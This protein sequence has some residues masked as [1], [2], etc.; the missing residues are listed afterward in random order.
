MGFQGKSALREKRALCGICP[1]GCWVIVTYDKAGR[2]DK[3]RPDESSDL[4]IICKLGEHSADIVYS[5]DR[6]LYPLRRKGP[7]GTYEFER[8]SWDT[9]YD[10]IADRLTGIKLHFGPEANAVYTGRG[11]FELS[12]CDVFQPKGVAVSSASSILFPFGSP[13]TMGVGSL[14]YVSFAMIAPHVT[15]GGMLINMFS[16][17]ENAQLIV[18]WGANPATDCPPLDLKRI[19]EAHGRGAEVVVI[20]PRRTMTAKL[21]NAEWI[22]VRSGT[23]GALAL[24]MCNVL[25]EE[26]IYD[27]AFVKDWTVGFDQFSQYVQHFRPDV[28]EKITGVPAEKIRTLA[29]RISGA[30][31]TSPVMY[32]GLEYNDSGVQAIRATLVLWAL[33]GQLD[34]PGGR[35][36]SM[37][38]NS[39]PINREGHIQNPDIRKTIG[40]DCFPVYSLYRAESHP[41]ALPGAVIRGSPYPIRSLII[42]GA[43]LITAWPQPEIWRETLRSLDFLVCIDRQLTADAAYADI[44]LPGTTMYE[45]ESYMIYGPIFRIREKVIEPVGE[46]RND[47]F[48][49]SEL[50]QRLGYGYLYPRSEEELLRH[51]LKASGYTPE[52]VRARGGI[53]QIPTAMMQYKK[54]EKGL[55]RNDG[56]PGFNTPTGKFEIAS[57]I[58]EEYG[59]DP[60]PVYTEPKEGPYSQ[61]DLLGEFPL[62]FNSGSRVTTDFRS[63]HHGIP[64]LHKERPEPT[65][66]INT[67]DAEERNIRDG[68]AV[69]VKTVRGEVIMRAFVTDDIMRGTIDANMGGGGPVGPVA[70]QECNINELTDLHRYDPV[71]G[72]PVYKALL[73]DVIK[74]SRQREI[75]EVDSGEYSSCIRVPKVQKEKNDCARRIYLDHNATTPLL[76]DVLEVM[77]KCMRDYYGNPSSIYKEGKEACAVIE[78]SRRSIAQLINCTARRIFFTAGGSESNNLALKGIA[79]ANWNKKNHIITTEVEHPSVLTTCGWLEKF[80]FEITYLK[81]DRT[82]MVNPHDLAGMIT[83]KTCLVSVMTA[84]NEVGT[85]QP[86]AALADIAKKR[87]VLFHTDGIQAIGKIPV[88]VEV[89][90]I[91]L[92][93]MSGHKIHGP[94]GVGALYIRKGV[95]LEPLVHGGKQ[96]NGLRAGTENLPC[97]AGFGKAAEIALKNLPG[98]DKVREMRDMLEKGMREIV[99]VVK[100]NGHDTERL[101]NTLNIVMPGIRGE[102]LILALDQ[103]G[104]SLSS[105]SACRAGSPKPSHVLLAT[106]LSEEDAHCSLRFSLGIENTTEEIERVLF[107]LDEV[108]RNS[109]NTVRFV[110]C[111]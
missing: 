9:A 5:A 45:I 41:M 88:D 92:L 86:I 102:S 105:G 27:D 1:A 91:D 10:I 60:L 39:F 26:E 52:D 95:N 72:F 63:Q 22:P 98:M 47:F 46:A 51:V 67:Q 23:D 76:P 70:W 93:S 104:V 79:F 29:M 4:G 43:S 31:G 107:L 103:K 65:V 53:V 109:R 44:V 110:P 81:A 94:K 58:L 55:L 7:K 99:P 54:W 100:L 89:L 87:G 6:L 90:G 25:I 71:S 17:I 32:S 64:A 59:Y 11:S 57:T 18:V 62:I 73:C 85:I 21:A 77:T 34:V 82:G 35:C 83:G 37:R 84:N 48:I 49:M 20:D 78:S 106:G 13:N 61:P 36:F 50:A 28:V 33:A 38:E 2:I 40:R 80:G 111:R 30:N 108:L 12:L 42:L 96:E 15:M 56:M 68:D 74:V 14:C 24:G 97:I 3:V 75:T 16:D 8:I 69:R 19:T 66:T 101:P